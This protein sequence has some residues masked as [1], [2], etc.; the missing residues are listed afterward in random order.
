MTM[1]VEPLLSQAEVLYLTFRSIIEQ[2]DR[3]KAEDADRLAVLSGGQSTIQT[4]RRRAGSSAT[5][6]GEEGVKATIKPR[7]PEIDESLREL[8]E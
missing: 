8:L 7:L 3:R 4:V 2:S 6:D 1:E 5:T